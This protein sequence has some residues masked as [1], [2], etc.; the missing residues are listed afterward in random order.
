M[1]K[2][3]GKG[4]IK[5]E[6]RAGDEEQYENGTGEAIQHPDQ[7]Q[8]PSNRS[9]SAQALPVEEEI[10]ADLLARYQ[11]SE[12]NKD[13]GACIVCKLQ[14]DNLGEDADWREIREC[15]G[16]RGA[17]SAWHESAGDALWHGHMEWRVPRSQIGR[18]HV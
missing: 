12:E 13:P 2:V 8:C 9:I 10:Q 5:D 3:H 1:N 17:A 11:G 15:T 7:A 18:A 14:E 16:S 4:K 6:L